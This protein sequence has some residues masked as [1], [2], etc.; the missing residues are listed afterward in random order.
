M[1]ELHKIAM[2]FTYLN[3]FDARRQPAK[4]TTTIIG[5]NLWKQFNVV[6]EI[7]KDVAIVPEKVS[8]A[9]FVNVEELLHRQ[10]HQICFK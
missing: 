4:I 3:S 5:Q 10:L 2:T 1:K 6:Q 8:K 9:K 7:I